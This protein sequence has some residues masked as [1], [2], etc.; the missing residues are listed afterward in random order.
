M[1]KKNK[2]I[3]KHYARVQKTTGKTYETVF[4]KERA[5][6][7]INKI[8]N[9]QKGRTL[10]QIH[11]K[12]KAEQLKKNFKL[13][14]V[15]K[16]RTQQTRFLIS[17]RTQKLSKESILYEFSKIKSSFP[18]YCLKKDIKNVV[19]SCICK[20][21]SIAKYFGTFNNFLFEAGFIFKRKRKWNKEIIEERMAKIK[22]EYPN[23]KKSDIEK[24]YKKLNL[25]NIEAIRKIYNGIRNFYNKFDIKRYNPVYHRYGKY[26]KQILDE[27]EEKK[28]YTILR[29]YKILTE[30]GKE[31]F[32]DGFI[33]EL[34]LA[35]EVF[36]DE[37]NEIRRIKYDIKRE[38]NIFNI[39][40]CDFLIIYEKEWLKNKNITLCQNFGILFDE[41]ET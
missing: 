21:D 26:E 36:E 20:M 18:E 13:K 9:T 15:G 19:F 3:N 11:G 30:T 32:L 17:L 28:G 23:I 14:T 1:N 6:E 29:Q 33:P 37:H 40:K 27:L 24:N 25:P 5:C 22:I 34:N 4:G 41:A 39:L 16:K 12:E 31:Y 10:E 8:K 38:K 7:I 2:Y 35:I